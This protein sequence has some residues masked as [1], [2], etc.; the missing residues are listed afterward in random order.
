MASNK[1]AGKPAPQERAVGF[2]RRAVAP[3]EKK[4]IVRELFEPIAATYDRADTILSAGL[5][6]R[7]RRKAI[8]LLRLRPGQRVLDVC[9]GTAGLAVLSAR[10]TAPGG[11]SLVYDFSEAMMAVGRARAGRGRR[12]ARVLFVRGDAE[13]LGSRSGAFDAVTIG[14][15]LRNLALPGRGLREMHRVLKPG[16]MLMVLEFSL[17]RHAFVRRLYRSY[18]FTAMPVLAGIICGAS[19][20]FRY[21]AESISLFPPPEE[22]AAM[23]TEAGFSGVSFRRLTDGIA[24][25]YLAR[26]PQSPEGVAASGKEST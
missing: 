10:D 26:K 8:A 5:D 9:G 23:I 2:G 25:I 4:R 15:G 3:E 24:V 14:F 22:V 17:P 1:A 21:L 6:A 11:L 18:S 12:R 20:P 13:V 16:G 19:G 7:W